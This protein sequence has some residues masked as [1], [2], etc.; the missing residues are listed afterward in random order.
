MML[1][2]QVEASVKVAPKRGPKKRKVEG[3]TSDAGDDGHM[4]IVANHLRRLGRRDDALAESSISRALMTIGVSEW[5]CVRRG[6]SKAGA[7]RIIVS[8]YP[9]GDLAQRSISRRH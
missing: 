7:G 2:R 3:S 4:D 5:S 1:R 6:Q 9:F 8:H